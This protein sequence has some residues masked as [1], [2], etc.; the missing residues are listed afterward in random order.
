M[1]FFAVACALQPVE[2]LVSLTQN[3]KVRLFVFV[4]RFV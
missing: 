1:D 2:S 4:D 3:G